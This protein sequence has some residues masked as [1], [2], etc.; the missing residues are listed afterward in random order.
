MRPLTPKL[1]AATYVLLVESDHGWM[2]VDSGFG[3]KDLSN[4][5][6][7]IMRIFRRMV[8]VA[9]NPSFSATSQ[10]EKLGIDPHDVKDIV[11]THLHLDHAGGLAD[12]PWA[13]VHV[14]EQE[15]EAARHHRGRIGIGYIKKQWAHNPD[16]VFYQQCD[17]EW[18]DLPAI[19]VKDI[20]PEVYMIPAAGHTIGHCMVA[21][22][23]GDR[24]LLHCGDSAYPFYLQ[25]EEQTIKPPDWLVNGVL[26]LHIRTLQKLIENYGVQITLISSHDSV[27]LEKNKKLELV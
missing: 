17:S 27:S 25:K 10:I 6:P 4:R 2:L 21:V 20:E 1:E 12:F 5:P 14:L 24:W 16:W 11:L 26:G 3:K 19:R 7:F 15:F 13:K 22:Q 18:F 8:R 9:P 23:D